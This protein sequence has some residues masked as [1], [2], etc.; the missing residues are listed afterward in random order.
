VWPVLRAVSGPLSLKPRR[1]R[2]RCARAPRDR[3]CR[4]DLRRHRRRRRRD[5]REPRGRDPAL[6]PRREPEGGR[7]RQGLAPADKRYRRR[8]AVGAVAARFRARRLRGTLG[9]APARGRPR[10]A[11]RAR[12]RNAPRVRISRRCSGNRP[13]SIREPRR[14]ARFRALGD[15]R[16]VDRRRRLRRLAPSPLAQRPPPGRA[17]VPWLCTDRPR[18]SAGRDRPRLRAPRRLRARGRHCRFS[19]GYGRIHS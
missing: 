10:R 3:R 5:R 18:V 16:S 19:V 17:G 7:G 6:R 14:S 13:R 2:C 15:H 8:P 1:L 11:R 9:G 4:L 12:A